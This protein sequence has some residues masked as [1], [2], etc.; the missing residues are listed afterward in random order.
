MLSQHQANSQSQSQ[1][2]NVI[3]LK[4]MPGYSGGQGGGDTRN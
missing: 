1:K 3:I 4:V 2:S